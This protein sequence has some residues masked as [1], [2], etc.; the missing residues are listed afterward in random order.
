MKRFT[1]EG[2][3]EIKETIQ[4]LLGSEDPIVLEFEI[5]PFDYEVNDVLSPKMYVSL[6]R[7]VLSIDNIIEVYNFQ[8]INI[9]ISGGEPKFT[10]WQQLLEFNPLLK[11]ENFP[12][13]KKMD[14]PKDWVRFSIIEANAL[15]KDFVLRKGNVAAREFQ[16]WAMAQTIKNLQKDKEDYELHNMIY[17]N[18]SSF[19]PEILVYAFII[20]IVYVLISVIFGGILPNIIKSALDWLFSIFAFG[21][22]I[23]VFWASYKNIV[24][25]GRVYERYKI[26]QMKG[27]IS[28]PEGSTQS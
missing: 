11:S 1:W 23:W 5:V 15:P 28:P 19:E 2:Y 12:L 9:E 14:I 24:K 6:K 16:T 26:S 7:I 18:F 4:E 25:N 13:S 20:F 21:V 10:F 8:D 22:L 27:E 17:G 3:K